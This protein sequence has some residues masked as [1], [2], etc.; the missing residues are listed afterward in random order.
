[1]DDKAQDSQSQLS[2][3]LK[4][5]VSDKDRDSQ[6][7]VSLTPKISFANKTRNSQSKFSPTPKFLFLTM[8]WI[9]NQNIAL[10]QNLVVGL[11]YG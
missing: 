9:L 3:T 2:P 5:P 4:F 7:K 10:R 6:Q 11:I 8:R 1:M